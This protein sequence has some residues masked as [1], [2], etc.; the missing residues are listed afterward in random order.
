[1]RAAVHGNRNGGPEMSNTGRVSRRTVLSAAAAA[2]AAAGGA[3]AGSGPAGAGVVTQRLRPVSMAM[4]IHGPFS[5]GIASFEAHLSQAQQHAVDVIWWT[6]HDFR[7]AAHDHRR[8]VHFNGQSEPEGQLSWT[9]AKT[10][11]GTLA[12]ST[13]EFVADPHSPD[14]PGSALRVA[15]TGGPSA[16]GAV[17]YQGTAFNF[18]YSTCIADTTLTLDV[19]AEET[20][21][22][23][24]LVVQMNLSHHPAH[25]DRPA[26]L[27]S[28]R[29][30]IGAVPT[31]QHTANGIAGTVDIPVPVG[32]WQRLTLSPV[33]DVARIWPDLVAADNSMRALRI[34]VSVPASGSASFVVDRLTFDRARRAGQAGE[35]LRAEVL[36]NYGGSFPGVAHYRGYEVSLVRHL[37]WYGGDHTLPAFP[38]PPFKNVD[39]AATAAMVD[40]LHSHGGVVCWNH[41]MEDDPR[42]AVATLMVEQ[43]NLGA[44]LVE[45]GREPFA[46]LLWT[47]DVAARNAVFFTAIGTSDDHGGRDWLVQ[48]ENWLTYAWAHSTSERD[49][50]EALRRGAAWFTNPALYRGTVDITAW[51]RTVMGGVALTFGRE[52]CLDL[53]ATDL[54]ADWTLEVITGLVDLA[55]T[56]DLQ[57]STVSQ[58]VPATDLRAGKYTVT[59]RSDTATGA[60]VRTQV[61]A[62]DGAVV[63]VSNPLWLLRRLPHHPIPVRRWT[64]V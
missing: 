34:G 7:V 14:D 46:D 60:Y 59:V 8:A 12:V 42:D 5:E 48:E 10:T 57:P 36:A 45:I 25:G 3:A 19:L 37:N 61:R 20:A 32:A 55:G 54:P 6:D 11:E 30:R 33:S 4:H 63:A 23:A 1:M 62:A 44:D 43:N 51:G 58:L 39:P 13:V 27:Y 47:F 56:A 50:V 21:A 16:G 31:A 53:V 24:V 9:W 64:F 26:G 41:P 40:F 18:T 49:L 38:S 28:L 29:Y 2:A 22:D 15:A 17:W 52:V 35:D